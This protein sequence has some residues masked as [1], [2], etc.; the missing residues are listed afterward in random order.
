MRTLGRLL[1][2]FIGFVSL[3]GCETMKAVEAALPPM[4][5]CLVYKGRKLCAVKRDGAWFLSADLSAEERAEVGEM[6]PK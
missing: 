6:L 5:V 2:L 3:G 1:V 4:E